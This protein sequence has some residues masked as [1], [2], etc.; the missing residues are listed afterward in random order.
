MSRTV[1]PAE[2]YPQSGVQLTWP[3]AGTD[4][5]DMLDEVTACYVAI[6]KEILKR[7]KLLVV[8]PNE[9]DVIRHFNKEEQKPALGCGKKQRY[10]GTRP[11]RSL[12]IFGW[13]A[14]YSRFRIQCMG[15]EIR[16]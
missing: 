12:G 11:R 13:K 14:R 5:F 8:C 3:H 1:F 4:W 15:I 16:S 10:M 9:D 2:W 7:E 6:A